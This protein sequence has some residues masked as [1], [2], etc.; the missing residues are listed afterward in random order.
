M[1]VSSGP[2]PMVERGLFVRVRTHCVS[3]SK[4]LT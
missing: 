1:G 2:N 4:G 3:K